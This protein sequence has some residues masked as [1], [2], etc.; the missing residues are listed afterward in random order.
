MRGVHWAGSWDGLTV[1]QTVDLLDWTKEM[2]LVDQSAV[3]MAML[4][5]VEKVELP[6]LMMETR[7]GHL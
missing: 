6:D 4:M 7:L 2:C 1:R 5:D 3:M